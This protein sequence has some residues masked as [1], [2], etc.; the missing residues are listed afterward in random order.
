V[1]KNVGEFAGLLGRACPAQVYEYVDVDG[2]EGGKEGSVE[3]KEE[4]GGWGGKK[5][6]INSQVGFVCPSGLLWRG[7]SVLTSILSFFNSSSLTE[8]HPL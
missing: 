5:F 3:G 2:E 8:L 1:K 6:V 4:G 7:C